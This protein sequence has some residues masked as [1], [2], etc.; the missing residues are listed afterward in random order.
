MQLYAYQVK[1]NEI[2]TNMFEHFKNILWPV[3]YKLTCIYNDKKIEEKTLKYMYSF[4]L[5]IHLPVQYKLICIYNDKKTRRKYK[6]TCMLFNLLI[7][8]FK[9]IIISYLLWVTICVPRTI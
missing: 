3:Q 1:Y 4:H 6:N 2:Q 8:L 9:V 7:H 5:F